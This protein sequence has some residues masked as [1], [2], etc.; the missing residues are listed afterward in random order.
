MMYG[1]AD[2]GSSLAPP[3]ALDAIAS[4]P[5]A[6]GERPPLFVMRGGKL[7]NDAAAA[8][9]IAL[10]LR[11]KVQVE[12]LDEATAHFAVTP[13]QSTQKALA[14]RGDALIITGLGAEGALGRHLG[15]DA[16]VALARRAPHPVLAMPPE[17]RTIPSRALVAVDFSPASRRAAGAAVQVL[18]TRGTLLLAHVHPVTAHQ[19]G[20][21]AEWVIEDLDAIRALFDRFITALNVPRDIA[22]ER[23]VLHGSPAPEVLACAID[24]AVQMIAI[25][26]MWPGEGAFADKSTI[27]EKIVHGAPCAVLIAPP[28]NA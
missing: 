4:Q 17:Q 19:V 16:L 21:T 1:N 11:D 12:L 28:L 14:R 22:V 25:G 15:R 10:A 2:L 24:R 5:R 9:G 27:T 8:V 20:T 13:S 26:G 3:T 7:D 23:L 6:A 18:G